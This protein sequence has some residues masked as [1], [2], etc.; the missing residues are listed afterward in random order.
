M[1]KLTIVFFV[2]LALMVSA[3]NGSYN[4]I[5]AADDTN[6]TPDASDPAAGNKDGQ[7]REITEQQRFILGVFA[8]EG[9]DLAVSAD[10]AASLVTLWTSMEEYAQ[11]PRQMPEGT[12]GTPEETPA[13]DMEAVQPEDNSE[14]ISALFGQIQAVM[15][16]DQLAAIEAL[17]LDQDAVITFM[18]EQGIEMPEDVGGMQGGQTPQ[19]GTPDA[20]MAAPDNAPTGEGAGNGGPGSGADGEGTGPN[21]GGRGGAQVAS[22]NLVDAL[23]TL[24][25][26][27]VSA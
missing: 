6:P 17:E 7:Q 3:F 1:K 10:Q 5:V 22:S 27:K 8:L 24:L 11:Q 21:G 2:V 16:S 13:A 12:P 26:S 15:T 20:A 23:I 19:D 9:S 14:E 25:E 4:A 18:E